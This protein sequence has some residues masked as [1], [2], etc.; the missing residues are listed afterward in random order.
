LEQEI[1]QELQDGTGYITMP[2]STA[3]TWPVM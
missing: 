1:E 2:P 3:R